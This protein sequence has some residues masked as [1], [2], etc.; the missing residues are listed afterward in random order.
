M[1]K[2]ASSENKDFEHKTDLGYS[3]D[4]AFHKLALDHERDPQSFMDSSVK[5]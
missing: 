1:P 5:L 2:C 4:G 3:L